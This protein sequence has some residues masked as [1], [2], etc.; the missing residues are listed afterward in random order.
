[1]RPAVSGAAI[2]VPIGIAALFQAQVDSRLDAL[3]FGNAPSQQAMAASPAMAYAD[4]TSHPNGSYFKADRFA[5]RSGPDAIFWGNLV[6]SGYSQQAVGPVAG[7]AGM[8]S[9]LI[10]GADKL[11]SNNLRVGGAFGYA[12]SSISD[13]QATSNSTG[14]QTYEGLIYGSWVQPSWYAN[15]SLGYALEDYTTNRSINFPG[16]TD[17]AYG[18]HAGNLFTARI[19]GGYPIQIGN[20]FVVPVASLT[21]AYLGQDA[22]TEN[23]AAGAGLAV[24]SAQNNSLRS[25]LGV[26]TM[27]PVATSPYFTASVGGHAE[28]MHEFGDVDPGGDRRICRR[29][30]KLPGCRTDAGS[31]HARCRSRSEACRPYRTSVADGELLGAGR[32]HL[33]AAGRYAQG[34][35][36]AR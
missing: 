36:R 19:D 31:Q 12:L 8:T 20:G 10:V 5:P 16:F 15:A 34:A 11:V 33:P 17:S 2:Q 21:Y 28:W 25:E 14:L 13:N 7:Y 4:I 1:M 29:R 3:L 26:K 32:R 24:A 18:T 22:Y 27:V 9:G 30:W 23:S 35:L 6:Q